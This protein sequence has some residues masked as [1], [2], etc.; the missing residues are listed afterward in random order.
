MIQNA[1][2]WFKDSPCVG[3]DRLFFSSHPKD[4]KEAIS[5]CNTQCKNMFECRKF[6]VEGEL[7]LGV[8]GGMTG[9]Q[10]AREID[11]PDAKV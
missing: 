10:L 9:P 6:A 11:K 8:W 1:P 4:R 5:I 7:M 2:A 3:K